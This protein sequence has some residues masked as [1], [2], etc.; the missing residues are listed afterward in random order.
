M[1]RMRRT[2]AAEGTNFC[3][4]GLAGFNF[5]ARDRDTRTG[6]GECQRHAVSDS[7]ATASYYN[8]FATEIIKACD[9]LHEAATSDC[10]ICASWLPPARIERDEANGNLL[11]AC[12]QHLGCHCIEEKQGEEKQTA[13]DQV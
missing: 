10:S 5:A 12:I 4:G 8:Y 7:A 11:C 2:V 9:G 1:D 6:R 3:D 13:G